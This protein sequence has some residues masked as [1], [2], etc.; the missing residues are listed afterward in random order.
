MAADFE[1]IRM[2]VGLVM[3]ASASFF[4]LRTRS[5]S[6]LLWIFFAPIVVIL[7]LFD[8]PATHWEGMMIVLSIAVSTSISY[9][10]YKS[11]LLGGADMLALVTFAAIIPIYDYEPLI[12]SN[13]AIA[14]LHPFAPMIVLSNALVL[15]LVQILVNVLRNLAKKG[16]LFDGLHHEPRSK[17]I[18]AMII[19][20]RSEKPGY[21]FP[22][23]RV[24]NGRREFDFQ[25]KPAESAEYETRK[26]VWV[27]TATPF[28]VYMTVGL[29]IMILSGDVLAL[30]FSTIL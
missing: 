25:L 4:D 23:E 17:K 9:C 13:G 30:I 26:D 19:G 8:F 28:I 2:G 24:A 20:H 5:V 11:G 16:A 10:A 1:I 6:D 18:F 7:Y 12:A 29:V 21:A 15:S 27:T 22:L 14:F 3:F